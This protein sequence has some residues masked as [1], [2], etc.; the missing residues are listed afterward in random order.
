MTPTI[1]TATTLVTLGALLVA[2][3]AWGWSATTSPLPESTSSVPDGCTP[4]EIGAGEQVYPD[5]VLVS[6][7]NAGT[8]EGLASST[9]ELFVDQ[10][11]GF[12]ERGNAAD[13]TDVAR[14]AIWTDDPDSPATQLVASWLGKGVE[15]TTGETNAP[16]V[17]VVV[18]DR[19]KKLARG[20]ESV[21]AQSAVT[22]C[23]PEPVVPE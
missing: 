16:G 20:R 19:F 11:F 21:T 9:M 3:L 14:A 1:R 23:G 4:V 5:Q 18:G 22:L 7:L 8:K 10:G 17:V 6:V 13:G 15:I 12:G 2:G